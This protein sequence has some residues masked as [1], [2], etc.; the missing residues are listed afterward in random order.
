MKVLVVGVL[1]DDEIVNSIVAFFE[2]DRKT[3]CGQVEYHENSGTSSKWFMLY[4]REFPHHLR[5]PSGAGH[6]FFALRDVRSSYEGR[7]IQY[8]RSTSDV[9][10]SYEGR[11]IQYE[12]STIGYSY[13]K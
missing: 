13:F 11:P 4:K 10:S 12:R 3:I 1:P 6:N 7:P 8:E 2:A 5:V 9:R